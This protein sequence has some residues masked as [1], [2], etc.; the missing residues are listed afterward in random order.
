MCIGGTSQFPLTCFRGIDQWGERFGY[1][2]LDPMVG[3]IG[4][5]SFRDGIATGGQVR[6]PICRIGNVEHNE[7]SF[8]LLTLYR[9]ENTDSGGAGKY[10]GGNS[11]IT[12]FIPHGTREI[13]HETESSGAAI[14]TAPGLA[15][16]YPA[17]T[18]AYAFSPAPTPWA[19]PRAREVE[20][21]WSPPGAACY[22]QDQNSTLT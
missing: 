5:F 8:P 11:A 17:C 18:N 10:R 15:G 21:C 2:L 12:A 14:P 19:A 3:A 9:R 1:L 6:S 22:H 16:G 7:Q 13:E 20:Q 4:A